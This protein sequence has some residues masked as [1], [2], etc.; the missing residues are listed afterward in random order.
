MK[1]LFSRRSFW[2]VILLI[3]IGLFLRL[4]NYHNLFYF[5][6]D[7]EKAAYIIKGIADAAHFPTVG[8]PSSIGF[9]LG[10]LLYYL[11]APFYFLFGPHPVVWGYVSVVT[12]VASMILIFK[13]GSYISKKAGFVALF[14]YVFSYLTILYDRRGW[15]VSFHSFL[16]LLVLYSLLKLKEG[17]K[18]Y[19]WVLVATL[20]ACSQFEVAIILFIPFS[21]LVIL[22][23]KVTIPK[24]YIVIGVLIFLVSQSSLL[25]FDLRHNFINSKYLV[26][27]FISSGPERIKENVP[28]TGIREVYLTH[29]LLSST[30]ARTLLPSRSKNVAIEY[31]NCPQYLKFKQERVPFILSIFVVMSLIFFGYKVL[32]KWPDNSNSLFIQKTIFIFFVIVTVGS[33]IYT[34]VLQGEMAEYY[35]LFLF[36]YFFIVLAT[37][38]STLKKPLF[39]YG[40]VFL[41]ILFS[42]LNTSELLGTVNSYGLSYKEEAVKY[43]L[44][45]V[46]KEN[47]DLASFQT[48]WYSGGY[49]Y[50]FTYFGKEPVK[51]YMDQYL[52]EYYNVN[53]REKQVKTITILTPE[54]VGIQ[55]R[56]YEEFRNTLKKQQKKTFGAIEVYIFP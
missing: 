25:I 43:A 29:N 24:K 26:N 19:F 21:I 46:G 36:A 9:R 14:L 52:L 31:A 22:L 2:L 37:I 34:Y 47:F 5:A 30:L 6:I 1:R 39:R 48:C 49:R 51:S 3:F 8:H 50:L 27:Y 53:S 13:I 33:V 28:L 20:I 35:Y 17:R 42:Y 38:I 32:R 56:R 23:F 4:W 41:L 10:P 11:I 40:I 54:I 15:Q 18:K 44:K 7:E 55:P 12:S 45:T 16:A